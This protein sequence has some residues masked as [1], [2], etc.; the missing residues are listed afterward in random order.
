[1]MSGYFLSTRVALGLEFDELP[2]KRADFRKRMAHAL[3]VDVAAEFLAQ[4]VAG[5]HQRAARVLLLA[6]AVKIGRVADLRLDLLLAIAEVVVGDDGDDDAGLVAAGEL[7]RLAVVVEFPLVL[8]AHAVAALAFG[9]LVP[10][11]QAHGFLGHLDQMRRENHAAGVAGPMFRRPGRRRS[12]AGSDRRRC[13]RC[14]RRNP[15]C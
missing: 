7:E 5:K 9:G 6:E 12:P 3:D 11:R 4:I 10:V 15:G 14:F 8:P 1:M 13:R 2:V